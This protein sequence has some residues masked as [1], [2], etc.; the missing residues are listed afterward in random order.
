[1]NYKQAFTLIFEDDKWLLK[2]LI[3]VL[4]SLFS[5]LIIPMVIVFGYQVEIVE[6]VIR[7]E[8]GLPEWNNSG[9]K[10]KKGASVLFIFILLGLPTLA[11]TIPFPN[12]AMSIFIL[13]GSL[14]LTPIVIIQYARTGSIRKVLQP[15]LYFSSYKVNFSKLLMVTLTGG[16]IMATYSLDSYIV[17]PLTSYMPEYIATSLSPLILV[18]FPGFPAQLFLHN[19]YGQLGVALD[20]TGSE[21][22]V[23]EKA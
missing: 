1:M 7:K 22:S 12:M 15:P 14:L 21:H 3:G 20:E 5:L 8:Q 9:Q 16:L 19:L 4:Y 11:L 17:G 23:A 6:K 18:S 13:L 2:V 10:I